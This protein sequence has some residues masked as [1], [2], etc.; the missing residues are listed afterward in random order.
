MLGFVCTIMVLRE[1]SWLALTDN[2]EVDLKLD[3]NGVLSTVNYDWL[4]IRYIRRVL[5][6]YS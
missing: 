5:K 2:Y 1:E 6:K 3:W 4:F